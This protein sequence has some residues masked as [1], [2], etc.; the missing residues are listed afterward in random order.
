MKGR[1]GGK[2]SH[3]CHIDVFFWC[4]AKVQGD[5]ELI[6]AREIFLWC[7]ILGELMGQNWGIIFQIVSQINL[8]G[9]LIS[10][11]KQVPCKSHFHSK[12]RFSCRMLPKTGHGMESKHVPS[13]SLCYSLAYHS[14]NLV[15]IKNSDNAVWPEMHLVRHCN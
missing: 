8:F 9:G 15:Q 1:S 10:L 3:C 5:S 13:Y 6:S 12:G 7:A 11:C 4:A 14:L 2:L